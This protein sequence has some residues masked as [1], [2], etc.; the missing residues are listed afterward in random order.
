MT[1]ALTPAGYPRAI[2]KGDVVGK[3]F[4]GVQA[5]LKALFSDTIFSHAILP[6]HATRQTWDKI[7]QSAPCVALG[8]GGWRASNKPGYGF[9]GDLSFPLAILLTHSD[10]ND[11]YL[12]TGEL[13]DIGVAGVMAAIAGG[14][15]GWELG[16]VGSCKVHAITLPNTED[17][18]DD[19]SAIVAVELVF[20]NVRL[21]NAEALAEL[22]DF[23]SQRTQ[24]TP[25]KENGHE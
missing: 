13:R 22:E 10:P 18:F 19:R 6:P 3:A 15:H 16:D 8:L 7:I 24:I 11:L 17:W 25:Q 1:E 2:L 21:D 9:M 14:L 4:E 12:G 20:E 23:L 5:R